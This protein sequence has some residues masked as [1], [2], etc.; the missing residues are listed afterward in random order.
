MAKVNKLYRRWWTMVCRC[1]YACSKSYKDYGGRGIKV[2]YEWS[3]T[4]PNGYK[5]FAR[6]MKA[7][8]Y[9]E[10]LPRGAQTIDRINVNGNYEPS[11]CRLIS[12]L[13]QQGNTRKNV[14]V[15]YKGE[16]HH[17]AE[18]ERILGFHKGY[19]VNRMKRG[20]T[21]EKAITLQTK[22]TNKKYSFN[23]GGKHYNS[24][25]QFANEYSVSMKNLSYMINARGLSVDEAIEHEL[26]RKV[27]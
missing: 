14:Y 23:Y 26:N 7:Q 1:K 11:N 16:T 13:E 3:D 15:T 17:V 10:T 9:D 24:L 12:N 2:C 27:R 21:F 19:I 18:W 8:G 4:N 5:N 25:T 22:P 20:L 6:W